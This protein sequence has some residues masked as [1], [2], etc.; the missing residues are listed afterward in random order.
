[1]RN[2]S[3][4]T[5]KRLLKATHNPSQEIRFCVFKVSKGKTHIPLKFTD[6]KAMSAG[7]ICSDYS[8]YQHL[9][10]KNNAYGSPIWANGKNN[11]LF[12]DSIYGLAEKF[13]KNAIERV[14]QSED[15]KAFEER[16][17]GKPFPS[18]DLMEDIRMEDI[19]NSLKG[20]KTQ[21]DPLNIEELQRSIKD[22]KLKW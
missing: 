9:Q 5:I 3:K 8:Y 13:T 10:I 12:I 6:P 18:G 4:N 17:R 21:I 7:E 20:Q 1:M 22:I 11:F 19:R 14:M 15:L 2:P 16:V